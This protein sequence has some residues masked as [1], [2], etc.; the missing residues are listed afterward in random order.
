MTHTSVVNML[1]M[2]NEVVLAGMLI[3]LTVLKLAT[4]A[5]SRIG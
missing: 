3:P 2:L 1:V 5:L 4:R